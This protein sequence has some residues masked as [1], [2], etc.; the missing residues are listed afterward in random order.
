LGMSIDNAIG[1]ILMKV[2]KRQ[3]EIERM[4]AKTT[5]FLVFIDVK[6]AY[7]SVDKWAL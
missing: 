3:K 5:P 1:S 4:N 2:K 6:K 7:D